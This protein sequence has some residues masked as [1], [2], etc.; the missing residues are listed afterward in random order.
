MK[1]EKILPLAVTNK[2]VLES[3]VVLPAID[4]EAKPRAWKRNIEPISPTRNSTGI[5]PLCL[6]GPV[7]LHSAPKDIVRRFL[8]PLKPHRNRSGPPFQDRNGRCRVPKLIY[9]WERFPVRGRC[10]ASGG[11]LDLF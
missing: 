10:D 7:G 8:L 4:F 11:L 1:A 6:A 2:I 9:Y 3:T 5:L